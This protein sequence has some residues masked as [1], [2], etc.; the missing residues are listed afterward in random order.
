MT[1]DLDRTT[2]GDEMES[3]AVPGPYVTGGVPVLDAGKRR[4]SARMGAAAY[5]EMEARVRGDGERVGDHVAGTRKMV[6]EG[7]KHDDGKPRMDLIPPEALYALGRVLEYGAAKYAD[8]NWEQ[9]FAWGRSVAALKRHLS[10][11]EAG[12]GCD[13]ES[14]M[15]HLWHVATNAVFLLTFE[16]RGAGTDDRATGCAL[17]LWGDLRDSRTQDGARG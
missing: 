5:R 4:I 16:A 15:P 2:R 17:H 1:S 12:Q 3:P 7:R 9:G 8:R 11:W 13:P 10:A 14:G 6:R